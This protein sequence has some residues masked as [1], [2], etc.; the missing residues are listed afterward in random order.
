M[1]SNH[2]YVNKTKPA[3]LCLILLSVDNGIMKKRA[4]VRIIVFNKFSNTEHHIS[5]THSITACCN[6]VR[7]SNTGIFEHPSNIQLSKRIRDAHIFPS[8]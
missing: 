3:V 4:L 5:T 1:A 6:G 2:T 7:S 8:K